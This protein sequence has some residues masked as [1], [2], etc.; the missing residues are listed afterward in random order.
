MRDK[1]LSI[2]EV[3]GAFL[4][5]SRSF[6]LEVLVLRDEWSF[7]GTYLVVTVGNVIYC[8]SKLEMCLIIRSSWKFV[9]YHVVGN[10]FLNS[11]K[12]IFKQLEMYF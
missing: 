4:R 3:A 5:M 9:L 12:S 11:W 1:W 2:Q 7:A 10:V 8:V 6:T